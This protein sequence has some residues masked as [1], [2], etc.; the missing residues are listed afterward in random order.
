MILLREGNWGTQQRSDNS[1]RLALC[2]INVYDTPV[3]G[4]SVVGFSAYFDLAIFDLGTHCSWVSTILIL[5]HVF[6]FFAWC[7]ALRA[8]RDRETMYDT[9]AVEAWKL[10]MK[11]RSHREMSANRIGRLTDHPPENAMWLRVV[12]T[13]IAPPL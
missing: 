12:C 7:L 1:G 4:W 6:L 5:F 10:V 8:S 3:G 11:P 13:W 2:I 9:I